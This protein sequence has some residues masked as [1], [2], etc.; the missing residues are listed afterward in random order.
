MI[1]SQ[2]QLYGIGVE[3]LADLNAR[4]NPVNRDDLENILK[5]LME[6]TAMIQ[7]DNLVNLTLKEYLPGVYG[8]LKDQG[9]LVLQDDGSFK[10]GPE[11][12]QIRQ[13]LSTFIPPQLKRSILGEKKE[14][15]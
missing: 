4:G 7:G 1:S 5:T 13:N 10:V 12:A 3:L 14:R 9:V 6:R 15:V 8:E 2:L 11:L